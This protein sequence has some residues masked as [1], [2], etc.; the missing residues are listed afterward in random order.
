M[1]AEEYTGLGKHA[2]AVDAFRRADET[3]VL[4]ESK[5]L[6]KADDHVEW[7]AGIDRTG[8]LYLDAQ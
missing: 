1:N 2:L 6:L 3:F 5:G 8:A 7:R 4:A